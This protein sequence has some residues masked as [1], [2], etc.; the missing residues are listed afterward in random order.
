MSE[1][2]LVVVMVFTTRIV[3]RSM[4]LTESEM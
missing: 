3:G 2:S 1:G 4:M